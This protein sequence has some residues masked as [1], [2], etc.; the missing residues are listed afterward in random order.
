MAD[1]RS[2]SRTNHCPIC[3]GHL[4]AGRSADQCRGGFFARDPVRVWCSTKRS[5]WPS[6]SGKSWR[7]ELARPHDW[8]DEPE[9]ERREPRLTWVGDLLPPRLARNGGAAWTVVHDPWVYRALDGSYLH[10]AVRHDWRPAEDR[11]PPAGFESGKTYTPLVRTH[12]GATYGRWYLPAHL[13]VPYRGPELASG[14]A[15][16]AR[17]WI[18]E[19]ERSVEVLRELGEVV[20][21]LPGGSAQWSTAPDPHLHFV[22]AKQVTVVVDRDP[23]GE[24]WARDVVASLARVGIKP[25]LVRSRTTEPGDDIVDHLAAGHRL[26]QLEPFTLT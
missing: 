25:R 6:A 2:W 10:E 26:E 11:P 15:S 16:G 14:I 9:Q 17:I 1:W 24:G 20:T 4:F 13:R 5:P 7:W 21:T 22:G 19:G 8:E 12:E 3:S 18:A 23:A